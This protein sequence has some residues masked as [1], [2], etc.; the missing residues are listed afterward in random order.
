MAA[1]FS[2]L[3]AGRLLPP[4]KIPNTHFCLTLSWP[5]CLSATGRIRSIQKSN[6]HIGNWTRDLAVCSVIPRPITLPRAPWSFL[7]RFKVFYVIISYFFYLLTNLPYCPLRTLASCATNNN[8]SV[9][10]S[11]SYVSSLAALK[12]FST[13][14]S[15]LNLG[16]F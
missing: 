8:V 14:S 4:R 9:F 16:F 10:L 2:A 6:D 15:L 12:S 3:S 5:Q 1:R 13:S 7:W 11:F